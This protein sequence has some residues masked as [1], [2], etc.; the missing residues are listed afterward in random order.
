MDKK[1]QKHVRAATDGQVKR[2]QPV[3]PPQTKPFRSFSASPE[4]IRAWEKV[5]TTAENEA[6]RKAIA[7]ERS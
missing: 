6:T 5:L 3:V 4:M 2:S 1:V 7:G